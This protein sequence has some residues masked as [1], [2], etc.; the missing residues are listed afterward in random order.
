MSSRAAKTNP[1]V[2]GALPEAAMS[3]PADRP[4]RIVGIDLGT[5]NSLA[6]VMGRHG[7]IVLREA[8][9]DALIPSVVC[10][11]PGGDVVVGG[12]AKALAYVHP[13]RTVHSIKRLIGRSGRDL[14]AEI[15]R[16][17]YPVELD[18]R[19]LPRVTLDGRAWSPEEI[20]ALVLRRVAGTAERALG[21]PVRQVVIT[22]PAYFDDAQRQAT[23][24]A[25]EI[26]GL[27]CLR[28]VNEPTASALAFGI[29]G[30]QDGTV[31]VY[32][33]GG[34]TFDVSVLRI[35][36]GIFRVLSTNGDT[37]L[38]GDD[39]DQL[40]VDDIL[41]T[42]CATGRTFGRS[43]ALTP[44]AKQALRRSGEALK[45]QL[46]DRDEATLRLD[47]E[48]AGDLDYRL[49]R[50]QFEA[51]IAPLVDRTLER[52]RASLADA[53]LRPAEVDHALLVG[54]STRIPLVR[55]RL[56]DL[57]GKPARHDVDPDRAVALGAAV[58]ADVLA[59]GSRNLL[60]LD[61]IPLSLGIETLGGAM[62]K[63]ILRNATIPASATEEF[64]TQVDGQTAVDINVYQG[65]REL[66]RDCR[67]LGS[68]K[69]SG[70]PPMPAGLPR[71]AVTFL[72]DADGLLTVTAKEQRTGQRAQIQV[73]PTYGL[74]R[75]E[76][77]RMMEDSIAH[78][79]EDVAER[80]AVEARN[81]AEAMVRGTRRALELA[82]LPP[83]QTYAIRKAV[84]RIEDLLRGS[85][86]TPELKAAIDDLSHM[87]AQVADDV[88][89]NAVKKALSEGRV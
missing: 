8:D 55:A 13:D 27:Q 36:A 51:M 60:L 19:G 12:E 32:D 2:A 1:I 21:E 86:A 23:K 68:F 89:S 59:G 35:E 75:D 28:I 73:V 49:T 83:D 43:E 11:R 42:L 44:F 56:A 46:S 18:A 77:R 71:I 10:F 85:E 70:L 22:V 66:V 5:T 31:L 15:P 87:T 33:L 25:A 14:L 76:V 88:I 48:G 9:G 7:P 63:L 41:R 20:S 52:C 6:A 65:E 45:R 24:D 74:T 64:S 84:K 58:Q 34:G 62:S 3:Q 47:L 54:G 61:V 79:A 16:L 4:A 53:G 26:A 29:D 72:V 78:A 39:I 80:D 37:H 69:L 81:K 17:P 38:G 82:E 57:L 30:K 50:P 67:R 40:I